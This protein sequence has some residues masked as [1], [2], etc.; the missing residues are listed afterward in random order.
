VTVIVLETPPPE[1]VTDQTPGGTVVIGSPRELKVIA[2]SL[3]IVTPSGSRPEGSRLLGG[4]N[5]YRVGV[6]VEKVIVLETR[7]AIANS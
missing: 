2:K 1:T 3:L 7:F 5:V 4:P 6:A